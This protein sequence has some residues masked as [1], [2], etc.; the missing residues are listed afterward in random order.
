VSAP[1]PNLLGMTSQINV[2]LA[3]TIAAERRRRA[4]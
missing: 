4:R 3:Q 2:Q 1:Q